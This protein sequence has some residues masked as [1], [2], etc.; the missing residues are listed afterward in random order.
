MTNGHATTTLF[1]AHLT[2]FAASG[3]T[4]ETV[5]A[6]GIRSISDR[7][8]IAAMLNRKSWSQKL[9]SVWAVPYI[10][11][12]SAIVGWRVK[13]DFPPAKNGKGQ[14]YLSPT[15][16]RVRVY[17]PPG[18][19][20][21]I[22]DGATEIL[23]TEG[24]KKSLAGTQAGFCVLGLSGVDCWHGR[25]SNSLLPDLELNYAGVMV[26][27]AFDSDAVTNQHVHEQ[28]L[29]LAGQLK[30]RG[31]K[32]VKIVRLP[33]G[34]NGEKVGL[35]DYLVANG[36]GA[37]RRLMDTADEAEDLPPEIQ[38]CEAF[39]ADPADVA[40]KFI[41]SISIDGE[42]RLRFYRSE[43]FY[44][45]RGG[46]RVLS[47]DD[48][49]AKVLEFFRRDYYNVRREHVAN[50]LM[51]LKSLALVGAHIEAP[52]WLSAKPD[53]WQSLECISTRSGVIHLPSYA[54]QV[55]CLKPP[56]PRFFTTAGVDYPFDQDATQPVRWLQFLESLWGDDWQSI[57]T[58]REFFGYCLT[59][60][61]SQQK[62]LMIVGPKRSGKGTILRILRA[63]VGQANVA[64]PTLSSLCER[65]GLWP[66]LGKSVAVI[67]DA[68]LSGRA[69]QAVI[70]ER[71]LSITGEDAQ[72]IDRKNLLPVTTKLSTRFVIV[73][74]ELPRLGDASGAL[75]S[76]MLLLRTSNSFYGV[77]DHGL[78]DRLLGELPGILLWSIAGWRLLRKRGYFVQ[79]DSSMDM[80]NE[81]NDLSSP[82]SAFV[83]ER[84]DVDPQASVLV[85][86]LYGD[87]K[88]WCE[89]SGKLRATDKAT[90]GRDLMA[91]LP[92]VRKS[93][94]RDDGGQ[95]NYWYT[96]IELKWT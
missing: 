85:D 51:H 43:W 38:R 46:Y 33:S 32:A 20:Q 9:G 67:S 49:A 56:T 10:D 83:R 25:K 96:G 62:L 47:G 7:R 58:L 64:A 74:N 23:I 61:T 5:T 14:K 42:S 93:R 29:L 68:R 1:P 39:E 37:L 17:F 78:T 69:D 86:S 8:E 77:E 48:L 2:E 80:L 19:H 90:F 79:P 41:D 30:L 66:L 28:E 91:L 55:E 82:V 12:T 88:A 3:L 34:P 54:E 72:T 27:V 45:E 35:D 94:Q 53:D 22:A 87:W 4:A 52:T 63:L 44:W 59:P 6:A 70:V 75:V 84:C 11:A 89:A 36:A 60:D 21:R 57:A 15:G 24:E 26:Y 76:R 50:V 18:T 73:T 92:T 31:A 95:R 40:A 16:W 71:I 81:L 65:F 13:P